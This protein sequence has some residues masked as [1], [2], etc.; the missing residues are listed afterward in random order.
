M[1]RMLRS[2][3]FQPPACSLSH[4]RSMRQE[5]EPRAARPRSDGSLSESAVKQPQLVD[6]R[7]QRRRSAEL[8]SLGS[9]RLIQVTQRLASPARVI[10]ETGAAARLAV[11]ERIA[12]LH[13]RSTE[14]SS[15][16]SAGL[17]RKSSSAMKSANNRDSDSARNA[18]SDPLRVAT[19]PPEH[20]GPPSRL[21]FGIST[22]RPG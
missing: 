14:D 20:S 16:G 19:D 7:T 11:R 12:K 1:A 21:A 3:P 22:W 15:S 17:H 18:D 8:F 4:R 13:R 6:E 10:L 2:R 9:D 5:Q